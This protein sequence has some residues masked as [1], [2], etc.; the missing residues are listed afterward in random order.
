MPAKRKFDI[1]LYGASGFVGKLTAG[2]LAEHAPKGLRVALA[3]RSRE[4]LE[5]IRGELGAAA[6]SW[7]IVL[8][9]STEPETLDALAAQTRAVVSTVGPYRR[10]GLALVAACVRAGTDYADLT[11]EVLFMH[12]SIEQFHEAAERSGARIVHSCGFDTIPSDLGVFLLHQAASADNAGG[13]E[14]TTLVVTGLKGGLSGGTIDSMRVLMEELQEHPELRRVVGDPYALSTDRSRE[15]DLGEQRELAGVQHDDDLDMWVG[16]FIMARTNTRVVRRSNALFDW[17]YGPRFRYAE[18][19]GFGK[20]ATAPVKAGAMS[21][22]L[23]VFSTAMSFRP[24]RAAAGRVLPKPGDGP[25]EKLR[26]TG[27]FRIDIHTRT[28]SGQRYVARVAAKGDPGYAATS[29]MLGESGMCLALDRER[30]PQRSGVLTPA[31]AMGE[32][33]VERLRA[34]GHTYRVT[35]R[36]RTP[37]PA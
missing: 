31:T 37:T 35:R 14:D 32:V 26:R 33:L 20:G 9:D 5:G 6:R 10:G 34:A 1:T 22:T 16:P 8:A 21:A 4:R 36:R 23:A 3:G 2:Y 12:D 29:V 28:S 25:D 7:P 18:V 17:A 11:G 27:F 13:L 19:M 15:P 24:S 30:L